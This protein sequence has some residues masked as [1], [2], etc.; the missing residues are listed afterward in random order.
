M[1]FLAGVGVGATT[2]ISYGVS[3]ALSWELSCSL[4]LGAPGYALGRIMKVVL[5]ILC[6]SQ[7][8]FSSAANAFPFVAVGGIVSGLVIGAL[9]NNLL[10]YLR[11]FVFMTPGAQQ[12]LTYRAAGGK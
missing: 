2:L 10:S 5:P 11:F 12:E 1:A 6:L 8:A 9:V 3:D 7:L 4:G